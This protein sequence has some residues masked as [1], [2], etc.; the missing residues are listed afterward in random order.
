MR[1]WNQDIKNIKKAKILKISI[2]GFFSGVLETIS[3][4]AEVKE[5]YLFHRRKK[6]IIVNL[7]QNMVIKTWSSIW[8]LL[9]YKAWIRNPILLGHGIRIRIQEKPLTHIQIRD[10]GENHWSEDLRGSFDIPSAQA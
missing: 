5:M 7:C 4:D 8:I 9:F 2:A 3:W 6:M 10:T 1:L